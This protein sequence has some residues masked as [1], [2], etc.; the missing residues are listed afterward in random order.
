VYIQI[1]QYEKAL[2]DCSEAIKQDP[3]LAS[4][5][6]NRG[7][8]YYGLHQYDNALADCTKAVELSPRD[9]W[10]HYSLAM[11]LNRKGRTDE[12]IAEYR[13]AIQLKKDF[14]EAHCN[15][16]GILRDQG[17][18]REALEETR[19]GHELGSRNPGWRYPSAEWVRQSE[20]LVELDGRLPGILDGKITPSSAAERIELAGVCSLKRLHRAAAR[21]YE[22][23]FAADP[24][25]MDDLDAAHR[26]NA[27]CAAALAGCGTGKDADK[28][29]D[30]ER[31]RLRQQSLDWLRADLEAWGGQ[32]DKE[33]DKTRSAAITS[34]Q[35]WL[36]DTD[37]TGVRGSESL[38]KLPEAERQPWQQLWNKVADTLARAKTPGKKAD[39][40]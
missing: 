37:F 32:L 7:G 27:A 6:F 16:G 28:L 17:L 25:L 23:A 11:A 2:A 39:A 26:Y 5:W 24:K 35:H 29:E 40:K 36:E 21:F 19:R 3:K 31:A 20:R 10:T 4:A 14:A 15:L 30:R 9:A 12:A 18:F 8:A 13:G 34:L 1:R 22:E 38:A 33:P